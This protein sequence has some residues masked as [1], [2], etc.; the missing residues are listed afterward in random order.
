M[1]RLLLLAFLSFPLLAQDVFVPPVPKGIA[2][3]GKLRNVAKPIPFPSAKTEWI[4]LHSARFDVISS[5]N[6][7]R[8]RDIVGDLDTLAFALMRANARFAPA[9]KPAT[10]FI[11]ASRRESQPYFDLLFSHEGARASGVYVRHDA[12]GT[13][14][15]DGSRRGGFEK[16]AMHELVHDLLR[17]GDLAPPLWLEEGLAEY[18][19]TADVRNGRVTAGMPIPEHLALL[20]RKAPMPLEKLFAV[21]AESDIGSTTA[22]YAQSWA[23][24]DWLMAMGSEPFFEFLK[25]IENGTPVE[26]A[27]AA[28]FN[29]TLREM[30]SGIRNNEGRGPLIVL[31]GGAPA[32]SPAAPVDRATLLFELGSFLSHVGGAETESQRHYQEALKV[33]PNHARTLAA[34]GEYDRAVAAAPN[35]PEVQL[36][37]AESLLSTATGPFAGVFTPTPEDIPKFRKARSLADQALALHGDEARARGI[38]GTSYLVESDLTPGIVELER[39]HRLA[40]QR[41]DFALNLYAMYLRT[42]ARDKADALYASTFEHARDKQT[43]FAARNVLVSTETERANDLAR[44]GQLHEAAAI[45]RRLIALTPDPLARRELEQQ[46][47]QLLSTASINREIT[48]YNQAIELANQGKNRDAIK[49]LDTL[50]ATAKDAAVIRDATKLRGELRKRK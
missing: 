26:K 37:Y 15:I 39:A 11:F 36:L 48:T 12:G 20:K 41:V 18:F 9:V 2:R 5:A 43:V 3:D 29:K 7:E 33:H 25:D 50:L 13:M 1:R 49:L 22:F 23:A 44:R 45:V 10:V 46:E 34:L 30:D 47:A 40:P 32:P 42:G 6:E 8:T 14:F 31:K 4:R 16:T 19:S 27:L 28:R 35:D 17:Q 24:V 21:P 38:R